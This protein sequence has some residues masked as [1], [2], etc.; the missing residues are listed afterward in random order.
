MLVLSLNHKHAD[1]THRTISVEHEGE[2]I[3]I[4]ISHKDS[5]A[6]YVGFAGPESFQIKRLWA[7]KGAE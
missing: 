6:V 3:L 2:I 5:N 1:P 7:K 4:E